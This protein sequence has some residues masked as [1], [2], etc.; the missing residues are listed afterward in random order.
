MI[1]IDVYD[2]KRGKCG[3]DN[4]GGP[5]TAQGIHDKVVLK[6]Q[7]AFPGYEYRF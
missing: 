2:E 1:A 5:F 3:A 7:M 4:C 6:N